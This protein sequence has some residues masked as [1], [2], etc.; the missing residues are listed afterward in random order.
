VW[1]PKEDPS[2][3]TVDETIQGSACSILIVEGTRH[4]IRRK[5]RGLRTSLGIW[6]DRIAK[7]GKDV[8]LVPEDQAKIEITHNLDIALRHLRYPNGNRI[9]WIDALC[10]DQRSMD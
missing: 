2:F 6:K 8:A 7:D 3:V 9:I 4:I 5:L 10:I 1:G